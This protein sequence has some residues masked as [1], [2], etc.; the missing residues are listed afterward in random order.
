MPIYE[1]EERKPQIGKGTFIYPSADV[2]GDVVLGE[3]CYIGPGARIRADYG[4]IRIGNNTAVEE[5]V[6]IHAR[7]NEKTIIGDFVTIGHAAIIHNAEIHD[8]VVVGMG[9]II[10]DYAE[11][12]KWAVIAE[13]AVIKNKARIPEKAIAVGIPGKVVAEI[14][15]DYKRQWTEYKKIYSDLA[16]QRFPA[17][18]K[19]IDISEI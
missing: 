14:T 8:W 5:N 4:A 6:V 17:S 3:N 7:P 15:S 12:R 1:F 18:L 13:G 11:I 16:R 19:K 2:I 9:A 10:S